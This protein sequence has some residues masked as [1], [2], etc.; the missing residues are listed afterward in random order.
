M[1]APDFRQQEWTG[2]DWLH[3]SLDEAPA[4]KEPGGGPEPVTNGHSQQPLHL[5][6]AAPPVFDYQHAVKF[7]D[8]VFRDVNSGRLSL[9]CLPQQAPMRYESFQ[10]LPSG[11]Q[12]AAEEDKS[13]PQGVFFRVTFLP[14]KKVDARGKAN[15]AHA[16]AFFW[17]DLDYRGPAHKSDTLPPD[18]DSALELIAELPRPSLLVHSGHGL[19][20]IWRFAQPVY[21]TTDEY[22]AEAKARSRGWQ[23]VIKG[24]AARRGWSYTAVGDLARVLRLPG[25]VNRKLD[26]ITHQ[27]LPP[28]LCRVI[29]PSGEVITWDSVEE[30]LTEIEERHPQ[31][32][33]R[34][35]VPV[36]PEGEPI[37][38]GS[39]ETTFY[40]R[41]ALNGE[42]EKLS[43]APQ[44]DRNNQ[45]NHSAFRVFQLDGHVN[46]AEA[47]SALFAKGEEIGLGPAEIRATLRSAMDAGQRHP[48][49]VELQGSNGNPKVREMSMEEI[50]ASAGTFESDPAFESGPE[51]EEEDQPRRRL[52][53]TCASDIKPR[54]V[55]WLWEGR[56]ALGTLALVAGREGS[57]KSTVCYDL[58]ARITRGTLPG[59]YLGQPKSVL[60]C[61]T[62]DSW[63]QTIVP[64]LIAA[65]A[66][67]AQVFRV[68][69]RTDDTHAVLQLPRDISAVK[70]A[71]HETNAAL[72]LLDPLISRLSVD[73][74][75]HKDA[76]VRLSLERL[77]AAADEVNLAVIG[78]IHHNK[79]GST[80]PLQLVMASKAFTAVAR[81]VHTVLL[82]P[83]DE[84]G[85]RRLFG[86]PKNNLGRTNLPTLGFTVETFIVPTEVGDA[87]TGRI[88]WGE[89]SATSIAEA[90]YRASKSSDERSA[91]TEAAGWLL[92]YL[93]E[94]GGVAA[95]VD[96]RKAGLEVGHSYD[97]LKKARRRIG[98][99]YEQRGFPRVTYW[100]HPFGAQS[101]RQ[102]EQDPRGDSLVRK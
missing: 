68:E 23:A 44:G 24:A 28:V 79:S 16:L 74:D 22:K 47:Y 58:A 8:T 10:S 57:G 101:E 81:S 3:S 77:V 46:F 31:Y 13:E 51:A 76:D 26:P 95:S 93:D 27:P 11:A 54:R 38:D 2:S 55:Q 36:T 82:D 49:A 7:L 99:P 91:T 35:E 32:F 50:Y 64:R 1:T 42:L 60:V 30:I 72:L 80:D 61:A 18:A 96:I 15:D 14:A 59:E 94:C 43:A 53:L 52:V 34:L 19:Y 71:A 29:E 85:Q 56:I 62:E 12:W 83:D 45:L 37:S 86:T 97:S 6:L 70:Q 40:G 78:L 63:S 67:L 92:D 41:G 88:M 33:A 65:N 98:A 20:P 48:R 90:M 4:A 66:D 25:S 21:L 102:S 17:A 87:E 75:S 89:E 73:L 69:V 100:L 5:P 39:G 84:T 9:C